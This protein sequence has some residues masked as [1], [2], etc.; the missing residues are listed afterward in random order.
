MAM[1]RQLALALPHAENFSRE[2]F[3]VG[4]SNEAA[5][6]LVERWPDWPDRALALVGPEGLEYLVMGLTG[7]LRTG[8]LDQ[9][10]ALAFREVAPGDAISLGGGATFYD[11]LVEI[12]KAAAV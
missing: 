10:F 4:T 5:L 11:N 9:D 8:L 2:D 3:L 6:R 7:Q 12:A 1:P